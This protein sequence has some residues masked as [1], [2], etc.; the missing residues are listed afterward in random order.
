MESVITKLLNAVAMPFVIPVSVSS[1]LPSYLFGE[2]ER[3]DRLELEKDFYNLLA[4][5]R[6]DDN[7]QDRPQVI[8]IGLCDSD[9]NRTSIFRRRVKE[10]LSDVQI[11]T[12]P[13]DAIEKTLF[14][15]PQFKALLKWDVPEN[16]PSASS[17]LLQHLVNLS[18]RGSSFIAHAD[19]L[20]WSGHS[21]EAITHLKKRGFI[22]PSLKYTNQSETTSAYHLI[23]AS[24]M[25]DVLT[26][27]L[28]SSR[29]A[30]EACEKR[31]LFP[32]HVA[33]SV[34]QESK[35]LQPWLSV[36]YYYGIF[37]LP[38]ALESSVSSIPQ[39]SPP[40]NELKGLIVPHYLICKHLSE[41]EPEGYL[42]TEPLIIRSK[43]SPCISESQFYLLVGL[44]IKQ[45]PR[46]PCCYHHAARIRIESHILELRLRSGVVFMSMLVQS[47]DESFVSTDTARVCHRV[48]DLLVNDGNAILR[49]HRL[50][51]DLQFGA[52]MKTHDST[53]EFI[54]LLNEGF[55]S[56]KVFSDDGEEFH[57]ATSIYFWFNSYGP[58]ET[59]VEKHF[60][61]LCEGMNAEKMWQHLIRQNL[62]TGK[63]YRDVTAGDR[64]LSSRRLLEMI[65][66]KSETCDRVLLEA[67]RATGQ[68]VLA[69][70]MSN[71]NEDTA[72]SHEQSVEV[73]PPVTPPISASKNLQE[74]A[75]PGS[76]IG[77][78]SVIVQ[79]TQN[80]SDD[81]F[82]GNGY[83]GNSTQQSTLRRQQL[84]L[85]QPEESGLL[86][87]DSSKPRPAIADEIPAKRSPQ[88]TPSEDTDREGDPVVRPTYEAKY[89]HIERATDYF[90]ER[91]L[92]HGGKRLG[93][94]SFG[95]VYYGVLHSETGEKHEVAIK[96][97]KNPSSLN[98]SQLELSK[99]QFGIELNILSRYIHPNVVSLL[100]FSC[101]GP[102]LALIYE[103]MVNGA[104]SHRLDCRD[105]SRPL[106]WKIRLSIA[107][108]I[109]RALCFLHSG[110]RLPV[111]H[112]DVKSS[113]V[114]LTTD[115][116]AKL[117]DFGL[118][119]VGSANPEDAN[120]GPTV[121][122]RPYMSPEAFEK[123][124]GCLLI[125]RRRSRT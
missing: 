20:N 99:K 12:S 43:N 106:P 97:F 77:S 122:T 82:T 83:F 13:Q 72:R 27:V 66:E 96:R 113:N 100:G 90:N 101:D 65:A 119:V 19:L 58:Q 116:R 44:L 69:E 81:R 102:E 22:S 49:K 40:S 121:G 80:H 16:R 104:L 55:P 62:V 41:E 85:E 115:F 79:D 89:Y 91:P 9:S 92:K 39:E 111:I 35:E 10:A 48:K 7:G 61:R 93:S 29:A 71:E 26:E 86:T 4:L 6:A 56:A 38:E 54:D 125:H 78:R 47:K 46:A 36:F 64:L 50:M 95:V 3:E 112:R 17:K 70:I 60:A 67:L 24:S 98:L 117:S 108:D 8:V 34:L 45:Y 76:V 5:L 63:Q 53:L 109:A 124:L 15:N 114:L 14:E 118:A 120:P 28:H 68:V 11:F 74:D 105:N 42:K 94:G 57:P 75:N 37:I 31:G 23:N 59:L 88:K 73:R 52:F 32:H 87:R 123:E 51:S 25:G 18:A 33:Q 1:I 2:K 84:P 110:H 103:Y 30:E 107:L 21:E